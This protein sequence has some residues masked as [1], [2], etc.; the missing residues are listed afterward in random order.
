MLWPSFYTRCRFLVTECQLPILSVLQEAQVLLLIRQVLLWF[1]LVLYSTMVLSRWRGRFNQ[2]KKSILLHCR[3]SGKNSDRCRICAP[4]S[5]RMLKFGNRRC[6]IWESAKTMFLV[7]W[8]WNAFSIL[9]SPVQDRKGRGLSIKIETN[10]WNQQ[11]LPVAVFDIA[12]SF[13]WSEIKQF[14][15]LFYLISL[16]LV[17]WALW[18]LRIAVFT[19]LKFLWLKPCY[20]KFHLQKPKFLTDTHN[21][22]SET[23]FLKFRFRWLVAQV[24]KNRLRNR[25]FD[26]NPGKGLIF[27]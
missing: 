8:I 20:I 6:F 9:F 4:G 27:L 1:L 22:S 16:I 3:F 21:L 14:V 2:W 11:L 10:R 18:E 26:L 13:N 23:K 24:R 5:D 17:V 15:N 25:R 7:S 19:I 12:P